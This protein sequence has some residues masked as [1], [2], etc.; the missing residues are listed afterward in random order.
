[1]V[2]K[3]DT[4]EL[5]AR[6]SSLGRRAFHPKHALAVWIYGSLVGLHEAS[7]LARACRTD[8]ALRWLC[9]GRSPSEAT[10]KRR[11]ATQAE[12]FERAIAQTVLL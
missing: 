2:E 6:F 9:G 7:K 5:E 11:R 12:F 10:L 8:A 1:M 3:L 4:S